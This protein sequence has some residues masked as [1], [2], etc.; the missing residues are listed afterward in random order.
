ITIKE[1]AYEKLKAIKGDRSFSEVIED[2]TEDRKP[3]ISESFGILSEEE[4]EDARER[5]KEF[6]DSFEE[7]WNGEVQS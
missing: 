4:A 5:M 6:E 7:G 1:S 3:D 2:V